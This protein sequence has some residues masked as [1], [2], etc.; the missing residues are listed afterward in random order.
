[1]FN[2]AQHR[3]AIVGNSP[4][5][6]M[7]IMICVTCYASNGCV[8]MAGQGFFCPRLHRCNCCSLLQIRPYL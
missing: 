4:S 8:N 3:A 7:E 1:M 5:L 6:S 2:P